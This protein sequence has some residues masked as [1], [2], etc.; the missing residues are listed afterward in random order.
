[1]EPGELPGASSRFRS[2]RSEHETLGVQ[3]YSKVGC[4]FKLCDTRVV[5]GECLNKNTFKCPASI[6]GD[7]LRKLRSG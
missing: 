5:Q 2:L 7:E 6:V 3:D 1:M 4:S